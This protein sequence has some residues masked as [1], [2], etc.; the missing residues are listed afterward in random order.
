MKKRDF[1]KA[2]AAAAALAAPVAAH[3]QGATYNWKMATGWASG[4]LMDVGAKLFAERLDQM[5]GGRFK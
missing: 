1:L 4:P 5:S 2:G 3:A